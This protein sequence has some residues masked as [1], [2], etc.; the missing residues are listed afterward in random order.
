[1]ITVV[2]TALPGVVQ[3]H[4]RVFQDDRGAFTE[5]FRR[6]HFVAAG[7]PGDWPQANRS[8]SR[9]GVVRGLHFQTRQPQAKLVWCT[10]GRIWD[11]AVDVRVGSPTFG[12]WAA[13]ELDDTPGTALFI[14]EGFAHGFAVLADHTD[15]A[16][17]CS[18]PYAPDDDWG[19]AWDDPALGI[20]WPVTQPLL[21]PKDR[22]H[23]TVAQ[24][25]D[26]AG[27][28]PPFR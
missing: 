16:Y 26:I 4:T 10:H 27:R 28:L 14:P 5:T 22:A 3:V 24:A 13:V 6:E 12:Q 20:P 17:L 23:P 8:R 15:V 2:P 1:V 21:S 25:A 18:A 7:L 19:V 11:V 9:Q